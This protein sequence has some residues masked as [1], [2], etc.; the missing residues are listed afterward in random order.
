M[1]FVA[2]RRG[3]L[4]GAGALLAAPAIVRASGLMPVSVAPNYS[5]VRGLIAYDITTDCHYAR[6]DV[7]YG[8][9]Q[10]CLSVLAGSHLAD[11]PQPSRAEIRA[12]IQKMFAAIER[13]EGARLRMADLVK[14]GMPIGARALHNL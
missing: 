13:E 9:K 3:F 4:L 10:F 1:S 6:F 8:K 7:I 5:A 14:P 11:P 2:S 12:N